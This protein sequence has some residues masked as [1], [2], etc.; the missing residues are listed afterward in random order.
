MPS[1]NPDKPKKTRKKKSQEEEVPEEDLP[2]LPDFPI[3]F[4]MDSP[5]FI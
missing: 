3:I 5:S 1:L 4:N 2:G